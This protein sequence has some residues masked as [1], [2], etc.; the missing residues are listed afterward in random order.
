MNRYWLT[1]E[2]DPDKE[3]KIV[4]VCTLYEQAPTLAAQGERVVS[5]DEMTGVQ[6][7]QRKYAGLPLLPGKV[8]RVILGHLSR[9]CNTPELAE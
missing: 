3:V 7:L 9:E 8:E 6:A 1:S 2:Q 5:T 4:D